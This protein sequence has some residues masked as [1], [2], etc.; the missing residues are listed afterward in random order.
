MASAPIAVTRDDDGLVR[1]RM[2]DEQHRNALSADFVTSLE[3][4]LAG[5]AQDPLAK[6]CLL[7]G[8]PEVFCSGGDKA[9]LMA[10]ARG[11]VA[12]SDILISRALLEVPIPVI[13]A[14][15]G[16]G[17][18]GGFTLGLCA[19]LVVLARESRYGA[20]FMNMGFTPGMGTT[21]LLEG[22]VG[23]YLAAEMMFG[24]KLFR[25]SELEGLTRVNAIVPQAEVEAH[26]EK[27]AARLLDKPR[28]ALVLLKRSLSVPRRLAFERAR[29]EET[30]MHEQC[31]AHPDT[32]RLI[33][34]DFDGS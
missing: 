15:R 9:M 21:A 27:L 7:S 30:F 33:E 11:E 13:A 25:G 5:L 17:V 23:P 31:F 3:E 4:A 12:S 28:H 16:H 26:A 34:D 1:L 10:L 18:G 24:G 20:T 22:A 32:L 8:L 6:V 19:D 2:Q 14:M 29:T